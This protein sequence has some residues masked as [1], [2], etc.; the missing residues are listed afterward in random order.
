M[1]TNKKKSVEDCVRYVDDYTREAD[2][3]KCSKKTISL[4]DERTVLFFKTALGG[5][6]DEGTYTIETGCSKVSRTYVLEC[7]KTSMVLTRRA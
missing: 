1:N 3:R 4:D 6:L 7:G 5:P 2:V